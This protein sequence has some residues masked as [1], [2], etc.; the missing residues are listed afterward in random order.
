MSFLTLQNNVFTRLSTGTTSSFYRD[1]TSTASYIKA[2]VNE[3]YAWAGEL[4]DWRFA[5]RAVYTT[6]SNSSGYYDYPTD[7]YIFKTDGFKRIEIQRLIGSDLKYQ[8]YDKLGS[9]AF[10]NY[11]NLCD[12]YGQQTNPLKYYFCD[13]NRQIHLYPTPADNMQMNMWGLIRPP[14]LVNDADKT[15]FD[16]HEPG[17]EEALIKKAV[18][19]AYTK[20]QQKQLAQVEEQEASAILQ[21]IYDRY[22]KRQGVARAES[23]M[24]DVPD[25]FADRYNTVNN[26]VNIVD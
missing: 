21:R 19:I 20:A 18:S 8:K 13:Y 14:A 11:K 22:Q 1:Q 2:I 15:I 24:W 5:E 7:P 4:F 26:N 17:A 9:D 23:P 16:D 10:L 12:N 3:A 25:Y 6:T